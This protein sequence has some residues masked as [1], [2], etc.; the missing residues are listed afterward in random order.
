V[1]QS[2]RSFSVGS[3]LPVGH[4][5]AEEGE[6]VITKRD[7]L[8][9]LLKDNI[10]ASAAAHGITEVTID[11]VQEGVA[12]LENEGWTIETLRGK[13]QTVAKRIIRLSPGKVAI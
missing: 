7:R 1:G 4:A 3:Y 8:L 6:A 2:Q 9:Q 5:G 12:S 11:L 13:E 10:N